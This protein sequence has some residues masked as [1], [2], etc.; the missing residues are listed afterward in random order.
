MCLQIGTCR[1]AKTKPDTLEDL[2]ILTGTKVISEELGDDLDLITTEHLGEAAYSVTD[3]RHTVITT[4]DDVQQNLPE[5]IEQV[6]KLISDE[7]NTYIKKK[8]E[9]RLVLD[10]NA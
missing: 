2:S 10:L 8:L 6:R 7:K 5:R 3:D 9:Q 1:F 4:L